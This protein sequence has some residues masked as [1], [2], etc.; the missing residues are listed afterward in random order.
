MILANRIQRRNA[1]RTR[2]Y[3]GYFR[4][5]EDA[6]TARAAAALK[7]HGDYARLA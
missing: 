4:K 1:E 5:L 6:A 2:H 3:L 7:Y